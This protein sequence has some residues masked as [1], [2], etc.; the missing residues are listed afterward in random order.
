MISVSAAQPLS[1]HVDPAEGFHV[2]VPVMCDRLPDVD[3][4]VDDVDA[5]AETSP[6]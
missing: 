6:P 5:L 4:V 3:V 1:D 2:V